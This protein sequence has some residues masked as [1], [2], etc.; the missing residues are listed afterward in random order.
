MNR[1]RI[2]RIISVEKSVKKL[3]KPIIRTL[4]IPIGLSSFELSFGIKFFLYL[5]IWST[6][7]LNYREKEDEEAEDVWW[8]YLEK[9]VTGYLIT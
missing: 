4:R 3:T 1:G 9:V 8:R 6:V 2:P 5:L 7:F